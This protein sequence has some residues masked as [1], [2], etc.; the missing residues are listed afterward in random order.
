M[1]IR[2]KQLALQYIGETNDTPILEPSQQ[3][4][5]ARVE[6]VQGWELIPI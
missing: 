4:G 2:W 1:V 5:W 3:Q 6:A